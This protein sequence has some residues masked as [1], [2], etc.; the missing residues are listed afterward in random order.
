MQTMALNCMS[1][2]LIGWPSICL[3]ILHLFNICTCLKDLKIYVP[4]AVAVD[5]A[6]TLSCYYNLENLTKSSEHT[7]TLRSVPRI[8]SGTYQCEVSA[9]APLFHTETSK[10]KMLVAELPAHQ[11]VLSVY[12]APNN[13]KNGIAIGELLKATCVSGPSFPPV[14]FTWTVNG[15]IQPSSNVGL[16]PIQAIEKNIVLPNTNDSDSNAK[17]A[18]SDMIARIDNHMLNSDNRKILVRCET[19]I[20]NLYRGTAEA[21]LKISDDSIWMHGAKV[22]PTTDQRSSS[23]SSSSSSGGGSSSSASTKNG[24]PDNSALQAGTGLRLNTSY[25]LLQLVFLLL[26]T[27]ALS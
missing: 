12:N 11:P 14:N 2:K 20:F 18:W 4:E 3:M 16:R 21:E 26:I 1:W 6:V 8:I 25:F 24:D 23:S 27:P 17:E 7:V 13:S 9:D 19:N 10:A 15:N 5:D 22:S